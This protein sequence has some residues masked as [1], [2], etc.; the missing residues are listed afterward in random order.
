[1]FT[2]EKKA[3]IIAKL[4]ERFKKKSK[5]L[6]CPMCDNSQFSI[7]DAYFKHGLQDDLNSVSIGGPSIP[8]VAIICRNCG[9]ISQHAIG[10]L[11]LLPKEE[12][13]DGKE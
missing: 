7:A 11:G 3:E 8:S 6:K 13:K 4:D 1:M 2:S 10:I 12:S 9:F 5:L